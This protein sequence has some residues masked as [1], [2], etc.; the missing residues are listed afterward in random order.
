MWWQGRRSDRTLDARNKRIAQTLV[1]SV[2]ESTHPDTLCIHV[3]HVFREI[4]PPS[5]EGID[6][7]SGVLCSWIS[8]PYSAA[9][10]QYSRSS[11]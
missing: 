11:V 7:C 4:G 2:D 8:N 1:M 3:D 5:V 9:L 6:L 10:G